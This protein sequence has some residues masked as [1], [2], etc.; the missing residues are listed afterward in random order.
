[1]ALRACYYYGQDRRFPNTSWGKTV[2]RTCWQNVV[3]RSRCAAS[4]ATDNRD[5]RERSAVTITTSSA[6]AKFAYVRRE[7]LPHCRNH[8][9]R[10]GEC[11]QEELGVRSASISVCAV[12]ASTA[13][14]EE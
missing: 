10:L 8:S 1:M 6:T 7:I 14:P 5:D 12:P 2:R 9:A 13:N 4:W 11:L 3:S